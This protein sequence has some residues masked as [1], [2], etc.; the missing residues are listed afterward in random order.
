[1]SLQG[2]KRFSCQQKLIALENEIDRLIRSKE[3]VVGSLPVVLL[4]DGISGNME[5]HELDRR[6]TQ[7]EQ[8]ILAN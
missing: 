5:A 2:E 6:I 4:D 8:R 3:G 7:L 1:M